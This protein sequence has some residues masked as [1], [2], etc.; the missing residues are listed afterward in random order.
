[1][2]VLQLAEL[3]EVLVLVM[4]WAIALV[5]VVVRQSTQQTGEIPLA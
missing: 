2:A 3:V 5:V 4:E 1:M